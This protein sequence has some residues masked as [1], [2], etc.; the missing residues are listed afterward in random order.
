MNCTIYIAVAESKSWMK[1]WNYDKTNR[2]RC[3]M[4]KNRFIRLALSTATE[5]NVA[6]T[7]LRILTKTILNHYQHGFIR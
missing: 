3:T 1:L 4:D 7:Q 6:I 2:S 5:H